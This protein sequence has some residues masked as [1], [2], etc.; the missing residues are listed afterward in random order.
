MSSPHVITD[1]L[2]VYSVCWMYRMGFPL[3][4]V[5][6][7]GARI[8]HLRRRFPV[9]RD[10]LQEDASPIEDEEDDMSNLLYQP[11]NDQLW[12][13]DESIHRRTRDYADE[14]YKWIQFTP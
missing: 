12:F 8:K 3:V 6:G 9:L 5:K 14:H 10:V 4:T 7:C 1:D 11:C 13:N 2:V